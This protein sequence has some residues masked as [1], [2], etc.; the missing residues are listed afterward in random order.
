MSN[1]AQFVCTGAGHRCSIYP[2]QIIGDSV[3]LQL[4]D[5]FIVID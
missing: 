3:S 5:Q 1:I 4:N 2:V